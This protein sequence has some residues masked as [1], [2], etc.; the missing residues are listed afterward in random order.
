MKTYH[1]GDVCKSRLLSHE[2][3]PVLC[4]HF[5][6]STATYTSGAHDI[7]DIFSSERSKF[8]SLSGHHQ[9]YFHEWRSHEWKYYRRCSRDEINL[10]LSL[11]N[12]KKYSVN[13][14]LWTLLTL[15]G[16]SFIKIQ[17]SS[18][19]LFPVAYPSH[20]ATH[21]NITSSARNVR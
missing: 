10:D 13:F 6:L 12:K 1:I 9:K 8:I 7:E 16:R 5:Q 18:F 14:M 11:K 19:L 20:I 17:Y 21:Y 4:N 2:H 15:S 3:I